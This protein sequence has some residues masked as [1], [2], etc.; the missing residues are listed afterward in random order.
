L[1]CFNLRNLC[2]L[3]NCAAEAA[4]EGGVQWRLRFHVGNSPSR[5]K[6]GAHLL[7]NIMLLTENLSLG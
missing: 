4:P 1:I 5:R 3:Q 2:R 6:A 7:A